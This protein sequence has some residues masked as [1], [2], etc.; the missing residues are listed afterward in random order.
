MNNP[1]YIDYM[2]RERHR[3]ELEAC[4]RRLL[5][6]SGSHHQPGF[7]RQKSTVFLNVFRRIKEKLTCRI[8]QLNPQFSLKNSAVGTKGVVKDVA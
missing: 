4:Q 7:F 2:I 1:H 6:K 5:L 8:K 3:D